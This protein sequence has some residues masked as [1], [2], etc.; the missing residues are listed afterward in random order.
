M[1]RMA[2]CRLGPSSSSRAATSTTTRVLRLAERLIRSGRLPPNGTKKRLAHVGGRLPGWEGP[3]G[4]VRRHRGRRAHGRGTARI[5]ARCEGRL[6]TSR[7]PGARWAAA[8]RRPRH[9][10][11]QDPKVS[12]YFEL[13]LASPR[14]RRSGS[15]APRSGSPERTWPLTT[16]QMRKDVR[17]FIR[18]LEA[19]GLTVE[20]R[21]G[22]YKAMERKREQ[23][24]EAA[25]AL[26]P[27][28]SRHGRPGG[29][30]PRVR[31]FRWKGQAVPG[32]RGRRR[33]A[34]RSPRRVRS[35]GRAGTRALCRPAT[36][37]GRPRSGGGE[38]PQLRSSERSAQVPAARPLRQFMAPSCWR[39]S[40]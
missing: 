10:Q 9:P 23:L 29:E 18:R 4:G 31:S 36:R 12:S 6:A 21:P 28:A 25:H 22:H 1:A 19:A 3:D 7:R 24:A 38:R 32:R 37:Q 34:P 11:R 14:A 39:N 40:S 2:Y 20:S 17:E 27:T 5:R 16:A 30:R 8:L 26:P 33:S 35:G 15:P 13:G